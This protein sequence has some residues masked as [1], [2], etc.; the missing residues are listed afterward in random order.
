VREAVGD[1]VDIMIEAHDRFT[2]GTATEIGRQLAAFAPYWFEAPV[3]STDIG[4]LIEVARSQPVR[5]AAGERFSEG[6]SFCELLQSRA[7]DIVQPEILICGGV[8]GLMQVA[9]LAS[10]YGA[11]IAPHNAQ[12]PFTTVVNAHVG[13]AMPSMLIQETFDDFAQPWA[14]RIMSGG[15]VVRDGYIDLP[16]GPGYGVTFDDDAMA[17][18]PYSPRNFLRLFQPGWEQRRGDR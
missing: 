5:V 1:D 18:Y 3:Q 9:A 4:A 13:A 11:W 16:G 6:S 10:A 17:E 15:C 7:I 14:Q 2:V 12:S 8:Q